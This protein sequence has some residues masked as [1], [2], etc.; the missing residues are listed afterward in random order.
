M[1]SSFYNVQVRI[2]LGF[3]A[4]CVEASVVKS[5]WNEEN[6]FFF[7]FFFVDDFITHFTL[8]VLRFSVLNAFYSGVFAKKEK[9]Q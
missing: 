8:M 3:V 1:N 6:I 2:S 7:S 5:K 9:E 4:E